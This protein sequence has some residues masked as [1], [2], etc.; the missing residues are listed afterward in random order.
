MKEDLT[1]LIT[2]TILILT[3]LDEIL[4]QIVTSAGLID[5]DRWIIQVE[6]AKEDMFKNL[7]LDSLRLF[8]SRSDTR[9][10][11]EIILKTVVQSIEL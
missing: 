11:L 4:F 1:I 8:S 9:S 3:Q 2:T 6:R 5:R 7:T 10:L